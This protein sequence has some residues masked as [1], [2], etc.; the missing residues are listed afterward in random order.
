MNEKKKK[1]I[2]TSIDLF[3][4]KGF[5][6]TSIQE[7]TD[8]SNVSKGAFYL[9]FQSKDELL[10]EIFRY[11]YELMNER[12]NNV[13]DE[14]LDPKENFINQVE[15]QF[16]EVL[17]HKNFIFT[18]LKEQAITFN[19]QLYEFIRFMQLEIHKWYEKNLTAIYGDEVKPYV[20]DIETMF[21][22][23]RNSY[24]QVLIQDT[25]SI[26][27][28]KLAL[29]IVERLDDIVLSLISNKEEPLLTEEKVMP[30][31][32]DIKAPEE[33]AKKE[34]MNYLLEMQKIL[35]EIDLKKETV[36]ELQGVIDFLIS[37]VK[38]ADSK[39]IVM[40]G[41]LANFKGIHQFDKYR[42]LISEKLDIRL[43]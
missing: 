18:Q 24:L 3:A 31:F 6:S 27:V 10:V 25:V 40:Q 21:E 1:I 13:I 17:N 30:L 19:K 36:N 16:Y 33:L 14:Q 23:I 35:N 28:P 39:K 12:I 8:K 15:V 5:Y 41:M 34:V 11:Y 32:S 2:V 37:E 26:K 38:K 4:D 20:I 29:F 42:K 43:L 7:I 22:G 9:H